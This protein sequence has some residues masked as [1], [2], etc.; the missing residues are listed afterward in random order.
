MKHKR[1]R[2][3]SWALLLVQRTAR[4]LGRAPE[5]HEVCAHH[6]LGARGLDVRFRFAIR[7]LERKGMVSRP[8]PRPQRRP[9]RVIDPSVAT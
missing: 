6:R 5:E 1:T 3:Q 8:P 4:H 9:L 2:L 7:G